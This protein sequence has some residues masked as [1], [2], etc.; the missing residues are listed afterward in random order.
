M[1][2]HVSYNYAWVCQDVTCDEEYELH[3]CYSWAQAK[4]IALN[5]SKL[6]GHEVYIDST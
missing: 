4:R 1:K 5:H 3:P 6:T 2:K